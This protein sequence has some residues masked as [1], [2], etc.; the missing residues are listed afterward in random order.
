[1]ELQKLENQ[2]IKKKKKKKIRRPRPNCNQDQ[3]VFFK[4]S[5]ATLFGNFHI[6]WD[7]A[8]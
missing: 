2:N 8:S 1:M 6:I 5:L 4:K 3:S 7:M